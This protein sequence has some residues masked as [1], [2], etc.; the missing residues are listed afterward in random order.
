MYIK[1]TMETPINS[2]SST[3]TITHFWLGILILLPYIYLCYLMIDICLQY[4]PWK[5][6]QNF[7]LL[8]QDVV[9]TQPWRIAFQTHVI[10]SSLI[11][12]A[13][14]TQFF[15]FFRNK[16]PKIHRINGWIYI[17]TIFCFALPSGFILALS[18]AGGWLTRLCFIILSI[19][20]GITTAMAL[21]H[22]IK[23]R[24]SQHR[25]WMIRSFALSLSALS[26]RS[27]KVLLYHLQPYLDFLTPVHIYQIEAWFGW[28]INLLIAE[29][30]IF[31][32]H[33]NAK[34]SKR[35]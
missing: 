1:K 20:W 9:Q 34:S 11:L 24:W 28:T 4:F 21:Y 30:I 31:K 15:H 7:L 25:N 3:K 26:L 2:A 35:I 22:A 6:D 14:L 33:Q 19:L 5:D 29:L 27:W 10:T 18:A 23:K 13:G 12:F 32:L 16:Y 17:L 8:K